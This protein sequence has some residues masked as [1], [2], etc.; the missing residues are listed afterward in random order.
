MEHGTLARIYPG[1]NVRIGTEMHVV[2][3][4]GVSHPGLIIKTESGTAFRLE[5][6]A[7]ELMAG[8]E[9]VELLADV[10]PGLLEVYTRL[11]PSTWSAFFRFMVAAD[12]F[13]LQIMK[14]EDFDFEMQVQQEVFGYYF[15]EDPHAFLCQ[16]LKSFFGMTY[17]IT[18]T[19]REGV[20]RTGIPHHP[21]C[22]EESIRIHHGQKGADT[23]RS[24]LC[25]GGADGV[26]EEHVCDVDAHLYFLLQTVFDGARNYQITENNCIGIAQA[27]SAGMIYV[28]ITPYGSMIVG[29][30]RSGFATDVGQ[31]VSKHPLFRVLFWHTL[32]QKRPDL[33]PLFES[34]YRGP[35]NADLVG[36]RLMTGPCPDIQTMVAQFDTSVCVI[37]GGAPITHYIM[38]FD[39][40]Y[41]LGC[42]HYP[43][44][45][46]LL[47]LAVLKN[48]FY[49][50]R[51]H[52]N[53]MGKRLTGRYRTSELTF[54]QIKHQ[55]EASASF[56]DQ[57]FIA[58]YRNGFLKFLDVN[59]PLR[60]TTYDDTES[61]LTDPDD[62]SDE[63]LVTYDEDLVTSD[64]TSDSLSDD[65]DPDSV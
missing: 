6:R 19:N 45:W 49:H 16:K 35:L 7:C 18:H 65:D 2:G 41:E 22:R 20:R 11:P 51:T 39:E 36:Q 48:G 4:F 29:E 32:L 12:G 25:E 34:A 21:A 28:H 9:K 53:Y 57:D 43:W 58:M 5:V 10:H 60:N 24:G 33:I 30:N 55:G 46:P 61:D 37:C 42:S 50:G 62:T 47:L 1:A 17:R 14:R 59:A 27:R 56:G 3:G 26:K 15:A 13:S 54:G 38:S 64:D 52:L 63:D 44:F 8:R 40:S 23:R 31:G